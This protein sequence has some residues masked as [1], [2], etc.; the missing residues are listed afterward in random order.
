MSV[1]ATSLRMRTLRPVLLCAIAFVVASPAMAADPLFDGFLR[2]S[3]APRAQPYQP[4]APTYFRWDGLYF[5]GHIGRTESGAD[6]SGGVASLVDYILRNDAVRNHVT[7]W[8]ILGKDSQM[9]RTYGV[10]V[11]YNMQWEQAIVGVEINYNRIRVTHSSSD[12]TTG[13]FQ[14]DTGAPSTHHFFYTATVTG[15]A[16]A[17]ITD[18][19]TLRARRMSGDACCRTA[20]SAWPSVAAASRT[21]RR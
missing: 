6:L 9:A 11:G 17:T 19:G 13:S 12:T 16:T 10:F 2:G 14:D 5:G 15:S 1:V 20:S 4:A 7:D 8:A 3:D 18:F 21:L